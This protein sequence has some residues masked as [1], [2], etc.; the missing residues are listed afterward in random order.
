MCTDSCRLI[1]SPLVT[2]VSCV[3]TGRSSS[4]STCSKSLTVNVCVCGGGG[5]DKW[6]YTIQ[7]M[8]M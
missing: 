3:K 4:E 7:Y 6:V 2:V 1:G 5:E 8:Y